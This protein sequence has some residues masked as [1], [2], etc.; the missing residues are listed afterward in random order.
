LTDHLFFIIGHTRL[1]ITEAESGGIK[2]PPS[3]PM[4][5]PDR[6]IFKRAASARDFQ[7]ENSPHE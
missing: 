7:E 5:H 1:A 2:D 4:D 3:E 6:R